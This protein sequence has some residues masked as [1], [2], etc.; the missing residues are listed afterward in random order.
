MNL[1]F[2]RPDGTFVI[3]LNNAPYHVIPEDPMWDD[4]K[5]EAEVMGD[6]LQFEPI[7]VF[8]EPPPR[9]EPDAAQI[10]AALKSL[11]KTTAQIDALWTL[12]KTI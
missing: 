5:A 11:G 1:L 7:P 4:T 3:E 12:A 2:K 6:A 8:P 9:L 10:K